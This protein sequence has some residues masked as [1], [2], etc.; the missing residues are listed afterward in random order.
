M[1]STLVTVESTNVRAKDTEE[2]NQRDSDEILKSEE[3][4]HAEILK[5]TIDMPKEKQTGVD[6]D[7]KLKGECLSNVDESS[8]RKKTAKADEQRNFSIDSKI[9]K[10]RDELKK[11]KLFEDLELLKDTIARARRMIKGGRKAEETENKESSV[12]KKAR[13]PVITVSSSSSSSR[14]DICKISESSCP[15]FH[16][17]GCCALDVCNTSNSSSSDDSSDD[18]SSH[19]SLNVFNGH[20]SYEEL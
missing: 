19:D 18:S 13:N 8:K 2:V 3:G 10:A 7:E 16:C 17:S 12:S 14:N 15:A 5:M 4:K 9:K 1:D 11:T 6:S 20:D